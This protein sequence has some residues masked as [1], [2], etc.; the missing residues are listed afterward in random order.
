MTMQGFFAVGAGAAAGVGAAAARAR[1]ASSARLRAVASCSA[2]A[3]AAAWSRCCDS[4]LA[5]RSALSRAALNTF[6]LEIVAGKRDVCFHLVECLVNGIGKKRNIVVG[7][8]N[9]VEGSLGTMMTH[10]ADLLCTGLRDSA[11]FS[12]SMACAP[13]LLHLRAFQVA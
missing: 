12:R 11:I 6:V 1:W 7:T 4:A 8:L 9:I 2:F 10:L 3:V 13:T 5:S